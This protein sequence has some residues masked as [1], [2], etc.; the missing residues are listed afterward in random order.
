MTPEQILNEVATSEW[1]PEFSFTDDL[2]A[3]VDSILRPHEDYFLGLHEPMKEI[4]KREIDFVF[5]HKPLEFHSHNWDS[6]EDIAKTDK[7]LSQR[8]QRKNYQITFADVCNWQKELFEYKEKIWGEQVNEAI[9][10]KWMG[11]VV[12]L[13]NLPN[14]HINLGLRTTNVNVGNWT[15]PHPMFLQDLKGM[16]FPISI[17]VFKN[18]AEFSY[19]EDFKWEDYILESLTKWY[20]IFETIHFFEDLNGRIGGIVINIL[21]YLLT[22]KYLIKNEK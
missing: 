8:L 10:N 18:I 13:K 14:R 6:E 11:K 21:S 7:E 17:E 15:P 2:D 20:K 12:E 9:D 3:V 4:I 22:G 5:E 1:Q 16:C 19:D